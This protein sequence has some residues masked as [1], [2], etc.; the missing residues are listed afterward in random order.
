MAK[1]RLGLKKNNLKYF[2]SVLES[3]FILQQR[4]VCY[5]SVISEVLLQSLCTDALH[6][7]V[8]YQVS[9]ALFGFKLAF[10][11]QDILQLNSNPPWRMCGD[12][13]PTPAS[14]V[15]DFDFNPIASV[16]P[17]AP[18]CTNQ[19]WFLDLRSWLFV[20]VCVC[21][22]VCV[23]MCFSA[24]TFSASVVHNL[25]RVNTQYHVPMNMWTLIHTH[26]YL[27]WVCVNECV[28]LF[29]REFVWPSYREP[30]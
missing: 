5:F 17:L 10:V 12:P 4:F 28:H 22:C 1:I 21:V 29:P 13:W 27:K 8:L 15:A 20:C 11:C 14:V 24:I 23:F 3:Y 26:M 2:W 18:D 16:R 6:R 7:C 9:T 19:K 30:L 25:S